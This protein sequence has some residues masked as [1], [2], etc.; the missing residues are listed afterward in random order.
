MDQ[1][2]DAVRK[3][4]DQCYDLE[5]EE[6]RDLLRPICAA[7]LQ[8]GVQSVTL[9]YAGC[10]D[11]GAIESICFSPK[12]IEVPKVLEEIVESWTYAILPG[13][14]EINEG[15]QGT[16]L[17]DVSSSTARIEHEQNVTES[18]TYEIG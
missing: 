9:E 4:L 7:L 10:G 5:G 17:I 14:W 2:L 12:T 16:V 11:D 6:A 13:G 18:E 1:E 8:L 3:Q 15:G